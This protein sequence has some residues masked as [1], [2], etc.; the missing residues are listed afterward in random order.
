MARKHKEPSVCT[1]HGPLSSKWIWPTINHGLSGTSGGRSVSPPSRGPLQA[2]VR[3]LWGGRE[4]EALCLSK[5][6]R[7]ALTYE[8]LSE[9]ISTAW[10]H[11]GTQRTGQAVLTEG[12]GSAPRLLP[13]WAGAEP[14]P[15]GTRC[16]L[17]W[18]PRPSHP[19]RLS[20]VPTLL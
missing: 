16:A 12:A 11:W 1:V 8:G 6:D 5:T 17:C 18:A 10:P 3:Q 14:R 9:L 19:E 13:M 20:T 15:S 4:R 7:G 2:E